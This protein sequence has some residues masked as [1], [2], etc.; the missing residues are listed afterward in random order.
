ME[1][2]SEISDSI[3][4]GKKTATTI[5]EDVLDR[6]ANRDNAINAFVHLDADAAIERAQFIDL[7]ISEGLKAGP[8]A[9]VPIG[10]KDNDNVRGMPTR[11][12]SLLH[13]DAVNA[14]HNSVHVDRLVRAGAIIIGK[15]ATAEFGL[16]GVTHTLLHGTTRNPHDLERTPGGSSGG[17]SAAVSGGMVPICTGS[18]A[19]GSIRCPAGFTGTLGL[20]PSHG[21]IP[22]D[23]G[24]KATACL[25]PLATTVQD[26]ARYLDVTSGPAHSDHMSL[27]R[28]T[29]NYEAAIEQLN[30]RGLRA[31]WSPDLGFAPVEPEIVDICA[32]AA[33]EL[34]SA[35]NIKLCDEPFSCTNVY[36]EWN[37]LAAIDLLGEF[38]KAGFLP[39]QLDQ[40]SP[41]PRQFIENSQNLPLKVQAA[42]RERLITLEREIADLFAVSDLLITPTACC[43]AYAAEGPMPTTIAGK[44]ASMTHAEPFTAIGSVCW[45]PSISIP[46]G[47]T[48]SGLPVGLL[49]TGPRHRDD[50]VLRLARIWEQSHP[51]PRTAAPSNAD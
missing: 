44:D 15:V 34:A 7:Q 43:A 12:G 20:K 24:F 17:S 41:G 9:G 45:N 10:I 23:H 30:V 13:R 33:R 28:S 40:I 29:V 39:G 21:R 50:L 8:L 14:Q 22:R 46:A 16:D 51:W 4:C 42:Y 32:N 38:E 31:T 49:L 48:S 11:F 19:L 37:A 1:S 35:A 5:I 3:S 47:T 6:I 26:I 36:H 27:P 18:D 2:A 25:G